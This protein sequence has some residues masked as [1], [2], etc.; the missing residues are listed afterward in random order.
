M[1]LALAITFMVT[2]I[3]SWWLANAR[4]HWLVLDMPNERSLHTRPTPRTGGIAIL[5]GTGTSL[6]AAWLW[7]GY[8]V[9]SLPLFWRWLWWH[10]WMIDIPWAPASCPAKNSSRHIKYIIIKSL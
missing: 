8:I 10:Y 3:I 6:L 7:N 2:G 1:L 5:L 9:V 4:G